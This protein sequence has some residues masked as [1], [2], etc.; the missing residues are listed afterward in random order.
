MI[1]MNDNI[2]GKGIFKVPPTLILFSKELMLF[3][4]K[5]TI[6]ST[7]EKYSLKYTIPLQNIRS[8]IKK[9][10]SGASLIYNITM[11]SLTKR[12][13][14]YFGKKKLFDCIY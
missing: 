5:Y 12:N 7:Y 13:Y 10:I 3:K 8:D 9:P 14:W 1:I 2:I 4:H 11:N 6:K